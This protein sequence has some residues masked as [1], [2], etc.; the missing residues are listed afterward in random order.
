M[1]ALRTL[2]C[3]V[4][5]IVLVAN[6]RTPHA[7][8]ALSAAEDSDDSDAE[9]DAESDGDADVDGSVGS[10]WQGIFT[11]FD[12]SDGEEDDLDHSTARARRRQEADTRFQW[13]TDTNELSRHA[14]GIVEGMCRAVSM[15]PPLLTPLPAYLKRC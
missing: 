12:L 15:A 8:L 1:C 5:R 2:P 4:L 3:Q 6:S 10:E 11:D 13:V 9:A 14:D 7:S